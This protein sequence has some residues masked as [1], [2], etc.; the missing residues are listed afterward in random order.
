MLGVDRVAPTW[1]EIVQRPVSDLAVIIE[2]ALQIG[3][4]DMDNHVHAA[5]PQHFCDNCK[6]ELTKSKGIKKSEMQSERTDR[7]D[8]GVDGYVGRPNVRICR[9]TQRVDALHDRVTVA[10]IQI[11][12]MKI[13]EAGAVATSCLILSASSP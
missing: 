1:C 7:A 8:N 6:R 2:I 5:D 9:A 3:Q 12:E 4:T 11:G 13:G 10:S